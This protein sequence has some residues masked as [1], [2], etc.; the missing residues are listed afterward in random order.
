MNALVDLLWWF[1]YTTISFFLLLKYHL[2]D[3]RWLWYLMAI[4]WHCRLFSSIKC[5]LCPV[6][7]RHSL[8]LM[9]AVGMWMTGQWL[10]D[11]S[12]CNP[13]FLC[14]QCSIWFGSE[15]MGKTITW[16]FVIDWMKW[17]FQTCQHYLLCWGVLAIKAIWFKYPLCFF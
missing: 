16:Y 4:N 7:N 11:I 17:L 3:T 9:P 15:H 12:I 8:Q 13:W 2:F 14:P 5:G 10:L 6:L 1:T